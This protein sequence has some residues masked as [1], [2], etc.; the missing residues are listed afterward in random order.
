MHVIKVRKVGRRKRGKG[1]V[2][3]GRGRFIGGKGVVI[4]GRGRFIHGKGKF[5]DKL[6]QATRALAIREGRVT[7]SGKVVPKRGSTRDILRRTEKRK[8]NR[9]TPWKDRVNIAERNRKLNV[10]C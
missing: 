8:P 6:A 1:V 9:R 3:G 7:I 5:L 10:K 4:G 2:I